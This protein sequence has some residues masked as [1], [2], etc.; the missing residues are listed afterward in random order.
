MFGKGIDYRYVIKNTVF[1]PIR[2]TLYGKAGIMRIYMTSNLNIVARV[3]NKFIP[4]QQ[5]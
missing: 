4:S 1:L 3:G 2:C 5:T